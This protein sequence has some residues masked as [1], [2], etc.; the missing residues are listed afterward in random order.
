MSVIEINPTLRDLLETKGY[1]V[2]DCDFLEHTGEYDRIVMNP[3][4]EKGQDIDHVRH[5]YELL[6][7]GGKLVAIMSE[8]SF[9]R[10]DK[11]ATEFREWLEEVGGTSESCLPVLLPGRRRSDRPVLVSGFV[12]IEKEQEVSPDKSQRLFFYLPQTNP[13]RFSKPSLR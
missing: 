5:A 9:Y 3:P 4:F 10:G 7:P 12:E 8:G 11:K 6:K 2:V 13:K 1:N